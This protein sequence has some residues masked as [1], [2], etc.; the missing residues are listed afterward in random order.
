MVSDVPEE[1]V[2]T[3]LDV[4]LFLRDGTAQN[5]RPTGRVPGYGDVRTRLAGQPVVPGTQDGGV[6]KDGFGGLDVTLYDVIFAVQSLPGSERDSLQEGVDYI[7]R[8]VKRRLDALR[9]VR[10][11]HEQMMQEEGGSGGVSTR[12]LEVSSDEEAPPPRRRRGP[13]PSKSSRFVLGGGHVGGG[14]ADKA[15]AGSTSS[16]AS[17][18][19]FMRNAVPGHGTPDGSRHR[20]SASLKADADG[21]AAG[22]LGMAL[23]PGKAEELGAELR[24]ALGAAP[25]YALKRTGTQRNLLFRGESQNTSQRPS[26]A[27]SPRGGGRSRRS[28]SELGERPASWSRLQGEGGEGGGDRKGSPRRRDMP[29]SPRS[30]ALSGGGSADS[31][32]AP[33][34]G[35]AVSMLDSLRRG[36]VD[37]ME[38][39]RRP[40]G[41]GRSSTT[42]G[43]IVTPGRDEARGGVYS[44]AP[45]PTQTQGARPSVG[46]G[47]APPAAT[48]A[49]V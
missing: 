15:R 42:A 49:A 32:S 2:D 1:Y 23:P 34:S 3:V 29:P 28:G 30:D 16:T 21:F 46:G 12:H 18:L 22:L 13:P 7:S 47:G 19:R 35:T 33:D 31:D 11:A 26:I 37:T 10:A 20:L 41:R 27:V 14:D 6:G 4:L 43:R 17:S 48:G 9:I 5:S 44:S 45:P 40:S 36:S 24:L 38:G 39:G 8:V 25:R